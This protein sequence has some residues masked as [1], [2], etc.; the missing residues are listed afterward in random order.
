ML[1]NDHSAYTVSLHYDRRLYKHDIVGSMAHV[2]MLAKQGIL[3]Q[4]DF[5]SIMDGLGQVKEEIEAGNFPW[6]DE[7]EDIHMNIERRLFDKIG[8]VAGKLHT[9]RS[10]N[11]QVSTD[12]RLYTKEAIQN[13]V[14]GV[15]DLRQALVGK[16]GEHTMTIMPGYTHVQRAQPVYFAHH[17]LAYFEMLGRDRERLLQAQTRADVMPLG[18]GALAGVPY[19]IDREMV[20][21]ELGFASISA[22]SLDAVSDRDFVLDLLSASST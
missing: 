13:L 4:D 16:A 15:H 6:R 8:D 21:R 2:R 14:V 5:D 9:A 20:A 7:L 17:M 12:M 22:N 11:D 1:H 19:P 3:P 10:R 18:S